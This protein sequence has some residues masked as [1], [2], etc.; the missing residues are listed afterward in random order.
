MEIRQLQALVGI[1]DHG[2][3]SAAAEA[4]GTVQSNI[5]ARIAR[6]ESELGTE[7]V[8]RTSGQLTPSG[9]LVCARARRVLSEV[10]AVSSDVEALGADVRGEVALGMIGTTG[11]WLVPPLLDAQRQQLPRV[12]LRIV[13][14]TNSSLEPRLVQ[15]QL[16]L[17]VISQPVTSV[18]LNDSDLFTED[19]VL[20]VQTNSALGQGADVI[21]VEELAGLDLLL[22]LSGTSIRREIDEACARHRVTLR[23][24]I[25]IDGMRTLASLAFDGYGPALVPA[26]A[27]PRHLRDRFRAIRVEGLP[28]RRVGLATR[29]Y[30]FPS[31]PVRAVRQLLFHLVAGTGAL[32]QGV[33]PLVGAE[34]V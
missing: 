5:S 23:P 14:G 22:P 20:I 6:L 28:P 11:R 21:G 4:L 15:G 1:A 10:T 26:T 24:I 29:R 12:G 13:E 19:L 25:E 33:H 7:L 27:L 34:I 9:D 3:F 18:D 8:E 32:P 16:D 2:S 30:G 17:A 31:T